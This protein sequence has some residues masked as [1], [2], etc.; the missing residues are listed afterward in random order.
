MSQ[1]PIP[2]S[3]ILSKIDSVMS[4]SVTVPLKGTPV[5][6]LLTYSIMGPIMTLNWQYEEDVIASSG[7]FTVVATTNVYTK[8]TH[9]FRTGIKVRVSNSGGALPAGL[10]AATDYYV[11]KLDAD[12]FK[13]A[14]SLVDSMAGVAIDITTDGSGT[15]TVTPQA[16]AGSAGS[17]TYLLEVPGDYE[18]DS[19][20]VSIGTSTH[21]N[22][23]GK[24]SVIDS[25]GTPIDLDGYVV[26]Y[27]STHLAMVVNKDF[28]SD[29]YLG[30]NASDKP[31]KYSLQATLP[32]VGRNYNY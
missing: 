31:V 22:I 25:A 13:I 24:C 1:A 6:D 19:N 20:F 5:V 29:S 4:A 17:G 27:D 9:G 2:L 28:V 18:I 15:N 23:V 7:A 8:S 21:S 11:I 12:T 14:A 10:A 30:I 16:V 26:A 32:I 3:V